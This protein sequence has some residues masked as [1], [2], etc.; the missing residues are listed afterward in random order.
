MATKTSS[1]SKPARTSPARATRSDAKK[2]TRRAL[3]V[4]INDYP[5]DG[6]DLNGCVNDA[7]AWAET[8][9]TRFGFP[10]VDVKLMTD[11]ECTKAKTL[12]AL[13]DLLAGA[14]SGDTLVFTNS[15]HGSYDADTSGDE[16]TYDEVICPYD[17]SD[18]Q[19][20]D[21]ELREL[22]TGLKAGVALTVILD[23]CFSGTATRVALGEIV[24]GFRTPDDRRVRFLS[25]ALR[26][27][28]V[29]NNPWTAK[30][31]SRQRYPESKMKEV[32][33]SG[34]TDKE[35]SYD[36]LIGGK[37][38]GAMTYYATEAIRR[39]SKPLTYV[40]LHQRLSS[41]IT[42]YPQHPQL[43]GKTANKQKHLFA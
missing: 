40:Q 2:G 39:S 18:N 25:P 31:K 22:F 26:G 16:E 41:L 42:D 10:A 20:V 33:L 12:R 37:Y 38:H 34:C 8:L 19:I 14:Q 5:Y 29:L 36:A 30:P 35:Y 7:H 15:S 4:G 13:G 43:E 27:M 32:L 11:A 23:N 21:D 1:R 17:I 28:K 24:P 3:C 6:N 9:T